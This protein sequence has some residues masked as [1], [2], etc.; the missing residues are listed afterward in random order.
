MATIRPFRAERPQKDKAAEVSAVPYDVVNTAEARQLA[1]DNPLSFLH[2]SRP[3]IDLPDGTDVYSDAVYAKARENYDRLRRAAP[4]EVEATPS[5]YVYRQQMGG[6]E[7]TG[8]AACCSIDEYDTDIIRKHER[9]RKDKEDD[10]TR[11]MITIGAQTGPVFLTYRGRDEINAII[12]RA[13]QGDAIADFTAADGVSHTVW[14]V[15]DTDAQALVEAFNAV[16]LLYIADGHH[17][18]ASAS[19]ARAALRDQNANHT[20]NEEYNY[21]LT[22]LFPADQVRILSYNRVVKDLNGQSSA[23]FLKA[24]S[25]QFKLSEEGPEMCM[26][27]V[28]PRTGHKYNAFGRTE[29]GLIRMYLDGKWYLLGISNDSG[30]AD[31]PIASL[32]VS[33]LQERVLDPLLGIKDVRT[34]K[35]IDFVGGVRGAETLEQAVNEGR[36]AVAFELYPVAVEELIAISDAKEIMPPKSTWFEPKLRDGLLSHLIG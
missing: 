34:D 24:L 15:A 11:H 13:K 17:R 16:P 23:K 10:R 25:K 4:L 14:R 33:I 6:H 26:L 20:G 3:E 30:R 1:A 31:D 8:L 18:A 7:Q 36:A 5:L 19:R 35:R 32:D 29:K 9:T 2:V 27:A 22:V 28:D 21:F 12:E